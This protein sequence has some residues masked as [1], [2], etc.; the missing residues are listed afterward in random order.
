MANQT[1]RSGLF[2]TKPIDVLVEETHE[3]ETELKRAVGP[4]TSP[5]SASAQSS[6]PASS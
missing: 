3:K 2:A 1:K 4:W 5:R 6:A